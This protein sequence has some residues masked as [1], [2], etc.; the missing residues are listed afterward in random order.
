MATHAR[1]CIEALDGRQQD[2][3]ML[4]WLREPRWLLQFK[5]GSDL[6]DW[7][8]NTMKVG[9][10]VLEDPEFYKEVSRVFS[11]RGVRP[12]APERVVANWSKD[13]AKRL[14]LDERWPKPFFPMMLQTRPSAKQEGSGAFI[15]F[16]SWQDAVIALREMARTKTFYYAKGK[17][18]YP[19][20]MVYENQLVDMAGY[21]YPCRII[22]DCDAK[23]AQFGGRYTLDQLR[24]SID[25][26]PQWFARRLVEIGAIGKAD[27]VV[28][29][30]KEKSREGKASRHYIFNV[31][32]LSTW[33]TQAVLREIFGAEIEREKQAEREAKDKAGKLQQPS[34][35]SPW[36]VTDPVPHH[37]RGQ[38]SVLGF[39]D[40]KK[41]ET[42]CPAITRRLEFAGGKEV[43]EPMPC[44]LSRAESTLD[45]PLALK[46]LHRACYSC[47]VENFVTMDAKY[48]VQRKVPFIF[49]LFAACRETRAHAHPDAVDRQKKG[50]AWPPALQAAPPAE[51]GSP[52][53]HR[54][55]RASCRSGRCQGLP[56]SRGEG[57]GWA[58]TR[59]CT[60]ST[61]CTPRSPLLCQRGSRGMA[62]HTSAALSSVHAWRARG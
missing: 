38:Y 13:T 6:L 12:V 15:V 53:H 18:L 21:D 31:V 28:A 59:A 7:A 14:C 22:L 62:W 44:R 11:E 32:G 3:T 61:P 16:S 20:S 25:A 50:R 55:R 49:T 17:K 56:A 30:E 29:Y 39:F 10:A 40:T 8:V 23:E 47:P 26:V 19:A 36:H 37:G 24:L 2:I 54:R 51:A 58:S 27:R 57:R 52:H 45:H 48:M 60:A 42:E 33:D 1:R 4:W 43:A 46:L 5:A 9:R 35:P 41:G 34:L